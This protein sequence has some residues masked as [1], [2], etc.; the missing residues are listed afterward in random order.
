[1]VVEGAIAFALF[2]FVTGRKKA[3]QTAA[4]VDAAAEGVVSSSEL[5]ADPG[6][7]GGGI[8][9]SD[10]YAGA[11]PSTVME[12]SDHSRTAPAGSAS[13]P[14]RGVALQP[15]VR[16][17]E[18]YLTLKATQPKPATGRVSPN[19][20]KPQQ[21]VIRPAVKPAL[22]AVVIPGASATIFKTPTTAPTSTAV[23]MAY[24]AT[25]TQTK[26]AVQPTAVS[27]AKLTAARVTMQ[28]ITALRGL[29]RGGR[30][31]GLG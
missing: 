11:R 10:R 27:A 13:L 1:M 25:Q 26:L 3:A 4:V 15:G 20:F 16:L 7:G 17:T 30:F 22:K 23:K 2:K 5:T 18:K 9:F 31:N 29:G 6:R 24:A 19:I 14:S 8:A 12:A 28:R 21:V